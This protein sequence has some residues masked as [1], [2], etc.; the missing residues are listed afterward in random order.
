VERSFPLP[1]PYTHPSP[2]IPLSSPICATVL[3]VKGL[4]MMPVPVCR[5]Q[6][7]IFELHHR[8]RVVSTIS[9]QLMKIPHH[10]CQ[11]TKSSISWSS[12]SRRS[13]IRSIRCNKSWQRM[14]TTT[15]LTATPR[16][17]GLQTARKNIKLKNHKN[18]NL[19]PKNLITQPRPQTSRQRPGPV[20]HPRPGTDGSEEVGVFPEKRVPPLR[21]CHVPGRQSLAALTHHRPDQE[22]E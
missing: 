12:W 14:R 4:R 11:T 1:T 17:S 22:P 19:K 5:A 15:A 10:H 6:T 21:N 3:C 13:S 7:M 16:T 18:K 9:V 8:K 20:V 2:H